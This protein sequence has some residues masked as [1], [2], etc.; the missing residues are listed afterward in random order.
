LL[1][2]GQRLGGAQDDHHAVADE[3]VHGRAVGVGEVR[4]RGEVFVDGIADAL[5]PELLGQR[6]EA[7][8]VGEHHGDGSALRG[9]VQVQLSRGRLGDQ[10]GRQIAA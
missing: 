7:D 6:R 8:K 4:N 2:F 3:L 9:G 5:G 10:G 1:L